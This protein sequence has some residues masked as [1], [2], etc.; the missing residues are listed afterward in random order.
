MAIVAFYKTEN[1]FNHFKDKDYIVF[2]HQLNPI[3]KIL[4]ECLIIF[5]KTFK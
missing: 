1:K 5:K 2:L 4:N 3:Y